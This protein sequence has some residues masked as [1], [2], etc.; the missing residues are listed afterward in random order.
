MPHSWIKES[1]DLFGVAS[2]VKN[3]LFKSMEQ[4]RTELY[5]MSTPIGEVKINRGIF[6]GD[7][8]SPLLFVI[9]LIPLS[10]LLRKT[11]Y[12]YDL[13]GE[14]V[15]HLL[16]MDDLKLYAKSEIGLESLVNTAR[17]F[18][19]DVGMVLESQSAPKLVVRGGKMSEAEGIESPDGREIRNLEEGT[20]YKYLDILEADEFQRD[21]MKKDLT[22]EYLRKVRKLLQSKLD[23]GHLISGIITRAVSVMRYS[24]S[25]ISWTREELRVLDQRTRKHLSM[26][27]ALRPRDNVDCW[28]RINIYRGLRGPGLNRA[29]NYTAESNERLLTAARRG[30]STRQEDS[31]EFKKRK[32]EER[33]K[34]VREKQIHGQFLREM[35]GIVSDKSWEWQE[36]A[37]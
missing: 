8:L 5:S 25:S 9:S 23:R 26:Y 37:I 13:N 4:W 35:N 22:K 32:R 3:L 36:K 19:A 29:R 12:G 34:E 24:V 28:Q 7:A 16:Y 10:L 6:Q 20:S 11:K 27:N 31:K 15:N 30:T 33:M 21:K 14:K 17:S 2:N 18:S 1:L